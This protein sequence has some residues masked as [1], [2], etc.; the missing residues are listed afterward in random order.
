MGSAGRSGVIE[1]VRLIEIQYYEQVEPEILRSL[2]CGDH[3]DE[4]VN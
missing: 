3:V 2:P 1:V 4:N